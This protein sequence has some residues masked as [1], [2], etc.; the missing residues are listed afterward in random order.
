MRPRPSLALPDLSPLLPRHPSPGSVHSWHPSLLSVLRCSGHI[1]T[2]GL[3]PSCL[4]CSSLKYHLGWPLPTYGSFFK[5]HCAGEAFP[6]CPTYNR[7][8]CSDTP[9]GPSRLRL[10]SLPRVPGLAHTVHAR[11]SLL[12]DDREGW[13]GREVDRIQVQREVGGLSLSVQGSG[14]LVRTQLSLLR[15]QFQSLVRELRSGW[16]GQKNKDVLDKWSDLERCSW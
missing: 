1:P 9:C 13:K 2:S 5:C 7:E 11:Y 15:A 6:G 3:D 12:G 4:E 10:T 8:S 14:L 16:H